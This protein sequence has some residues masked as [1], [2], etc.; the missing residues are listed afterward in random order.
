MPKF[1]SNP[2]RPELATIREI[3]QET[4][5][6]LT[7]RVVL[8]NEQ[9][10]REFSFQP[11]QVGQLSVFGVGESTFVI[12]SPPTRKDY[13]QFSV[14]CTGEVTQRLHQMNIGDQIGVRAPLGNG[15]PVEKLKGC[16]ILFIAGGIGMAP[17]RT[18]LLYM[19]DNRRDYGNIMVIYG[20]RSP[21]DLCYTYEFDE[22]RSGGVRLVLTVD[23]EFPGWKKRVG[24]VPTVLTEEAPSS[25]NCMA[26]TCGPPIMIKFVLI[27]LKRLDFEDHQIITTLEKRMKCGIGLCGRCNIGTKYVCVDGPVFSYEELR[28]MVPEI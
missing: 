17:L 14:M 2:F 22:W 4:S 10:M 13:L 19:L 20:A 5:N 26:V 6:I 25:Y 12:N 18:L 16:D 3:I 21:E 27:G 23:R 11:G 7:F 15:F 9:K 24:F 1:E 8:N 28:Q